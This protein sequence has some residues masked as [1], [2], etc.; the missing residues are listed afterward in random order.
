[1]YPQIFPMHKRP[2]EEQQKGQLAWAKERARGWM[3]V[4][5]ES[6]IGPQRTYL[7]GSRLTIADYFGASFVSLA[8]FIRC[9]FKAY[10]NLDRWYQG[11]KGLRTWNKVH[12]TF[13]GFAASMKDVAFERL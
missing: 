8:E 10:P 11:M 9:D 1:V 2:S 13:Y 6:L 4:L 12:E 3:K 5:D 7:C